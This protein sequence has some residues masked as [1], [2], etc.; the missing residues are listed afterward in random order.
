MN[1]L[2][3]AWSAG[4]LALAPSLFGAE[5][6]ELVPVVREES[7]FVS[8]RVEGAFDETIAH[9]IETGLEVNF[10][11]NIQLKQVRRM[12]PDRT[13]SQREI[14]TTVTY[15][16]LTQRYSLTRMVDGEIDQTEVVADVAE[17]R[18]F[19]TT[20]ESIRLFGVS[21][22]TPNEE[23]YLRA[24]GVMKEGNLLLLIPWNQ[25]AGWRTAYFTYL[26]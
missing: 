17:M 6:V 21:E 1:W 22:V 16:N 7:I 2:R 13:T 15:D 3:A 26:P 8:F 24:N 19:M 11:Y 10:R 18:R 25:G 12:W 14:R 23:Y 4:A 5:I 9:D 20:F